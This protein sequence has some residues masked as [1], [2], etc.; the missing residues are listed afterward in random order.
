MN[1]RDIF[2]FRNLIK[3]DGWRSGH[4][5]LLNCVEAGTLKIPVSPDD[6]FKP[7]LHPSFFDKLLES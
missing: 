1:K 3:K 5:R 2:G 6:A 7:T 4:S